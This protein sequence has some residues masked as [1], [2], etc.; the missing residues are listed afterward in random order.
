MA[1]NK[2][3]EDAPC[4]SRFVTSSYLFNENRMVNVVPV[5]MSQILCRS[6]NFDQISNQNFK[7]QIQFQIFSNFFQIFQFQNFNFKSKSKISNQN[8]EKIKVTIHQSTDTWL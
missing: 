7:F 5:E 6:K 3:R 8:S 1:E 2:T 4:R